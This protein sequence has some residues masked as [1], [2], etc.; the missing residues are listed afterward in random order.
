MILRELKCQV[1][2]LQDTERFNLLRMTKVGWFPQLI[3]FSL[4]R[5][6]PDRIPVPAMDFLHKLSV[7]TCLWAVALYFYTCLWGYVSGLVGASDHL[8]IAPAMW[9]LWEIWAPHGRRGR[10]IKCSNLAGNEGWKISLFVITYHSPARDTNAA[11]SHSGR[12]GFGLSS[13]L[14][15]ASF[16]LGK[17][18]PSCGILSVTTMTLPINRQWL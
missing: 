5:G 7:Y 9:A 13:A 11:P 10:N 8:G 14:K 12:D 6:S 4:N 1:Q 17:V 18:L 16:R 15:W 2:L 3:G